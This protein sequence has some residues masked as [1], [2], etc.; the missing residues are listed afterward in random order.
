MI[1]IINV[2]CGIISEKEIL[3]LFNALCAGLLSS[4]MQLMTKKTVSA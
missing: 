3:M 2:P 4:R 1:L